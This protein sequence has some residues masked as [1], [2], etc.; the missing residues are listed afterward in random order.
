MRFLTSVFGPFYSIGR[1]LRKRVAIRMPFGGDAQ[2]LSGTGFSARHIIILAAG[3]ALVPVSTADLLCLACRFFAT[4]IR[5]RYFLAHEFQFFAQMIADC[6]RFPT[7]RGSDSSILQMTAEWLSVLRFWAQN[8]P[9]FHSTSRISSI[10]CIHYQ[11]AKIRICWL[12]NSFSLSAS[13]SR[14]V[15]SLHRYP[16]G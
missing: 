2:F 8:R 6:L 10:F 9:P 15:T 4:P 16:V 5:Q 14:Y 1:N 7:D 13:L 11:R 12:I 3:V